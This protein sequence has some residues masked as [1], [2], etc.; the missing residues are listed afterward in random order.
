MGLNG[1]DFGVGS[2]GKIRLETMLD[3]GG[4]GR[5]DKIEGHRL[6]EMHEEI[7]SLKAKSKAN[8]LGLG[9]VISGW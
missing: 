4:V 8:T 2:G 5:G 6:A 3:H 7:C 1:G 9:L